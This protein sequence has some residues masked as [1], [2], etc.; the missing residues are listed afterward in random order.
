MVSWAG[1]AASLS[2]VRV[3]RSL[4]AVML[5]ECHKPSF[6]L[7]PAKETGKAVGMIDW[8]DLEPAG[9]ILLTC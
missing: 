5:T 3:M 9:L 1:D 6:K 8:G 7:L 2:R 4:L